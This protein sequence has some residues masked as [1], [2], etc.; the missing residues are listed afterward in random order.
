MVPLKM[1]AS[2]V[3]Q[4]VHHSKTI[5]WLCWIIF[6][7]FWLIESNW[8]TG[9]AIFGWFY[10]NVLAD[11]I[12]EYCVRDCALV[13]SA[14]GEHCFPTGWSCWQKDTGQL[15]GRRYCKSTG[16]YY[17]T[18]SRSEDL[19]GRRGYLFRASLAAFQ[20]N[21]NKWMQR[22]GQSIGWKSTCN[23]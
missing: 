19:I 10:N 1:D 22:T 13:L 16:K 21:G 9:V 6:T 11:G 2:L 23:L 12:K 8:K 14:N 15:R 7:T 3:Q 4:L 17:S 20:R 5:V 18:A